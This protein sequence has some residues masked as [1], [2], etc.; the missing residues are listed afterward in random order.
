MKKKKSVQVKIYGG[1]GTGKSLIAY[2]IRQAL[3]DYGIHGT[4]IDDEAPKDRNFMERIIAEN[5]DDF[6]VEI[7]T[8]QT[9]VYA[10]DWNNRI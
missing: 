4:L 3:T 1:Q 10:G 9:K 6:D 7:E 2:I 5:S 8:V